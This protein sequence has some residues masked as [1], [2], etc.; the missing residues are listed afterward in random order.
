[1]LVLTRKQGEC[2][3]IGEHVEVTVLEVH[4]N[5]VKLGFRSP[6]EVPIHR[7]EV[8]RKLDCGKAVEHARCA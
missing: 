2:V 5:R 1:M 4:G 7:Q 6:L 8:H 3:M